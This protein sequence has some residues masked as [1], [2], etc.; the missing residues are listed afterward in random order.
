MT[1]QKQAMITFKM[2][3]RDYAFV[4]PA[5]S[6][7]DADRR[8]RAIRTTGTVLGWPA[9]TYRANALTLPFVAAWTYGMTALRN[10]FRVKP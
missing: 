3:G 6:F 10:L 4:M 2:D 5:D 7:E 8:L 9:Y 1:S